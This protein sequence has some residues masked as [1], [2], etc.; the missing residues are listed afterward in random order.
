MQTMKP[1]P[2]ELNSY[3]LKKVCEAC[4]YETVFAEPVKTKMTIKWVNRIAAKKVASQ[5][6]FKSI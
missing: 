4:K 3:S 6:E 1:I 5:R 2:A